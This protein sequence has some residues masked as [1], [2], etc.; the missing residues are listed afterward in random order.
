MSKTVRCCFCGKIVLEER[1]NDTAPVDMNPRH[2]CCDRCNWETVIPARIIE[3]GEREAK[4][5]AGKN[6]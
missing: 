3:I 1:S 5:H 4:A 2:R 6:L